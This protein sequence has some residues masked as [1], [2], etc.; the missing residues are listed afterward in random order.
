MHNRKDSR[1][2]KISALRMTLKCNLRYHLWGCSRWGLSYL[3]AKKYTESKM[4][5]YGP[6]Q[7]IWGCHWGTAGNVTGTKPPLWDCPKRGKII[8]PV[9]YTMYCNLYYKRE[10]LT[11]GGTN[12]L[13]L[14]NAKK[15]DSSWERCFQ[16]RN[17]FF[18][19]SKSECSHTQDLHVECPFVNYHV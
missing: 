11:C 8:A 15:T 2:C 16:P 12:Q 7:S 13:V 10:W 1:G 9:K 5:F 14:S 19:H 17:A 18:L 3:P 4:Q 6:T